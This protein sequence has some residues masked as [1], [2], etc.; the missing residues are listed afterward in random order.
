MTVQTWD[1]RCEE[2]WKKDVNVLGLVVGLSGR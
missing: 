1:K 2:G